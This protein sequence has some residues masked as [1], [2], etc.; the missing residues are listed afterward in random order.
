MLEQF[1]IPAVMETRR[2]KL[3][4][5]L[6]HLQGDTIREAPPS[7]EDKVS[8]ATS[9]KRELGELTRNSSVVDEKVNEYV[10]IETKAKE[11]MSTLSPKKVAPAKEPEAVEEEKPVLYEPS[12]YMEPTASVERRLKTEETSE[13][14][15]STASAA[16]SVG[17]K[18]EDTDDAN[19]TTTTGAPGKEKK[20]RFGTG[21]N[22]FRNIKFKSKKSTSNTSE[23]AVQQNG[24]QMNGDIAAAEIEDTA[25]IATAEDGDVEGKGEGE[26]EVSGEVEKEAVVEGIEEEEEEGVA[27]KSQLEKRVPKRLGKSFNW[28]KIFGKLKGTTLTMTTGSKGKDLELAGCMV[29]PSDAATNGIELFSHKE[30]KQWVFRVET[31][32]LRQK[33]IEE[34]QKAIDESPVESRP[35]LTGMY[36][37]HIYVCM[38][39]I[40]YVY[41]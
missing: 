28:I 35:S 14:P 27:V 36:I 2:K 18:K 13:R 22:V 29:S 11:E 31:E 8:D 30:Q 19:G 7:Y 37:T 40:L 23:V 17:S 1:K 25:S 12:E 34:L 15:V 39:N 3:L 41:Y 9:P 32:E 20:K 16:S 6:I 21:L 26:I 24:E 5:R 10:R 4:E 33:W 38:Y